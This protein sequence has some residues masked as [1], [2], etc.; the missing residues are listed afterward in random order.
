MWTDPPIRPQWRTPAGEKNQ[1]VQSLT[2]EIQE[3]EG[4]FKAWKSDSVSFFTG[5]LSSCLID[6]RAYVCVRV[7]AA[8]MS[9]PRW[10]LSNLSYKPHAAPQLSLLCLCRIEW[11]LWTTQTVRPSLVP[12]GWRKRHT[13]SQ[14]KL[15]TCNSTQQQSSIRRKSSQCV[16]LTHL[17]LYSTSVLDITSCI[18]ILILCGF[19]DIIRT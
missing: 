3:V 1:L 8:G 14:I 17:M 2:W 11:F 19:H 9:P 10:F 4:L 7:K 12:R 6:V 18:S 5:K 13:D 16:M 15:D